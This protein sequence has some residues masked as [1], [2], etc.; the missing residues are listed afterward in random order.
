MAS[1]PFINWEQL[2]RDLTTLLG[3]DTWTKSQRPSVA[4][5]LGV[6]ETTVDRLNRD[7]K[8]LGY[9]ESRGASGGVR[10]KN[11][12]KSPIRAQEWKIGADPDTILATAKERGFV[13]G[14]KND[15]HTP[16]QRV[17]P[18]PEGDEPKY[19]PVRRVDP[20]AAQAAKDIEH[21]H[22]QGWDLDPKTMEAPRAN[23]RPEP[24]PESPFAVLK[25]LRKDEAAALVEAAR[26]Y[27][28]KMEFINEEVERFAAHGISLDPSV[29]GFPRDQQLETIGQVLSYVTTLEKQAERN[30]AQ[31]SGSAEVG[32]LKTQIKRQQ[33]TIEELIRDRSER[34]REATRIANQ[35]SGKVATLNQ[36][37]EALEQEL[38]EAKRQPVA[39]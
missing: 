21:Y 29:I 6:S 13:F 15:N 8:A 3:V 4:A 23:T 37:I 5:A 12:R 31:S 2:L 39:V 27:Q 14:G 33:L 11:G 9:F 25:P 22:V 32:D 10:I 38:H 16:K 36:K 18:R 20:I 28:S 26:Q 19:E 17:S 34:E 35:W 7:L 30:M 24:A 1:K